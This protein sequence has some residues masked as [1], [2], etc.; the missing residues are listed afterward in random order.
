MGS[1][2]N[3][4]TSAENAVVYYKKII[5]LKLLP[6]LPGATAPR[7]RGEWTDF[8]ASRDVTAKNANKIDLYNIMNINRRLYVECCIRMYVRNEGEEV[9]RTQYTP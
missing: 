7:A 6:L 3:F 5:P 1:C 9:S 2:T 4:T 8:F